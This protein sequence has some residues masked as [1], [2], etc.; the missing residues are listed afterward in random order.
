MIN[1]IQKTSNHSNNDEAAE[2]ST[3][4]LLHQTHQL[5]QSQRFCTSYQ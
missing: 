5:E 4:L 1:N 2:R 3:L